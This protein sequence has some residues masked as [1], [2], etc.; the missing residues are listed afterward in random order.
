[1]MSTTVDLSQVL[2]PDMQIYPGDS[3]F[4]CT[5]TLKIAD[6]GCSV[7]LM[8]LGSHTGDTTMSENSRQ[9]M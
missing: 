2:E 9:L 6:H 8:S 1:M 4:T 7:H 3:V 5:P